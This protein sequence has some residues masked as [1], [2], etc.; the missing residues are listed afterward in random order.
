MDRV[1]TIEVDRAIPPGEFPDFSLSFSQRIER[2]PMRD[3]IRLHTEIYR[4]L[5]R[6]E[7]LPIIL[8][9]TPYGLNHT[10][11]GYTRWLAS[12]PELA[13]EGYIFVFQDTRG[14]NA[15]EGEYVSLGP[16]RDRTDPEATDESTDAFDT[17]EW[18]VGNVA[19]NNGRVGTL[20]ISYGGFLTT[21]ALIDPHPALR[22][23]SPQATCADM[24]VGDDWHHNGAFRL[25]YAFGWM[26]LMEREVGN[27]A[28]VMSGMPGAYDAYEAFLELGPL[29][30]VNR[31]LFHGQSPSWNAFAE[32]PNLDDYWIYGMCGVLPHIQ[33][34]T[35][36]TLNVLG[37]FDAEDFY[38][39]LKVYQKYEE[40]D[41][42]NRNFLVIGPWSHGGWAG[43]NPGHRLGPV[44]FGS[45]TAE[46]YRKDIQARWF[47]HWLKDEG[48]KDKG[49]LDFPEA[50]VF[51]TGANVWRSYDQ[52]PPDK[53]VVTV[54][55]YLA[56]GGR[57]TFDPPG[58]PDG[59]GFDSYISDPDHPVPYRA[60]PITGHGGFSEWQTEDQRLAHGRP[61]VLSYV[62]DVLEADL[63]IAGDPVAHL[64]A[65]T[66]GQDADWVVK[67]IDVYPQDYPDEPY[68]G[69]F[70]FMVAGEVFRGRYRNSFRE[71]EPI[72]PNEVT[73]YE[74]SLRDR[75][76]T[77]R[78]GHRIMVQV[79]SSWFPLIDRN[80]QSWV[81]NIYE[82][83]GG[84]FTVATHRV[85][86]TAEFPSRIALRV[87]DKRPG[88]LQ[89]EESAGVP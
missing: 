21:R 8:T 32:H 10:D 80:P 50:R 30:N 2:V 16:V 72:P 9:R 47:A 66:S 55:V 17:I 64:F 28:S 60:R 31:K 14:R 41:P 63:T 36:P 33:P 70:Q 46:T 3:G 48:L 49:S 71:P 7:D 4:P 19:G 53:G 81:P 85:Y 65:S 38:G 35:V 59:D 61:D 88:P 40:S 27:V 56:P 45:N 20:G 39:P 82:A 24:F 87:I 77:F 37:W 79:Q 22:A 83:E 26:L 76:H 5:D 12:Y 25:E 6:D 34:V 58:E 15:S 43:R 23:A 73:G 68:M 89:L 67:L 52:W 54:D 75:H 74:I 78:K 86:R 84:D 51:N 69:G 44:S 11:N 18:L 29:S 13:R 62:S 42:K 57:L 1:A